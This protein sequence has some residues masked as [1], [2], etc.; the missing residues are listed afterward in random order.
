[1]V[2][3]QARLFKTRA[4]KL[5]ALLILLRQIF[6][7]LMKYSKK[8]K[9]LTFASDAEVTQFHD[10]LTNALREIMTGIGDRETSDEEGMK[11]TKAFFER[12]SAL[13]ET[14]T[15]LRAF[16]PQAPVADPNAVK[17]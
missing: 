12:Y 3:C 1:M 16:L 13:A 8:T 9:T 2:L 10:Q 14:L 4:I 7:R 11:Q 17:S 6:D 5:R 15:R